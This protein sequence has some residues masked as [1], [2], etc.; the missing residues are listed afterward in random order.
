V[1]AGHDG[2]FIYI[3]EPY[4]AASDARH[5]RPYALLRD[6]LAR[7]KRIAIGT[8]ASRKHRMRLRFSPSGRRWC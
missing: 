7:T 1:R 4:Y 3:D 5:I 8:I 2:R 6:A